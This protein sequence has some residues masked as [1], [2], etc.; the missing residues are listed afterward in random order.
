MLLFGTLE[1]AKV[2]GWVLVALFCLAVLTILV[3]AVVLKFTKRRERVL[4]IVYVCH[5]NG[6]VGFV[7]MED[8]E[9]SVRAFW[10]RVF[11]DREGRCIGASISKV[12][13]GLRIPVSPVF[14]FPQGGEAHCTLERTCELQEA[15]F[16][17]PSSPDGRTP[18]QIMFECW[19]HFFGTEW[20]FQYFNVH[21]WPS[22]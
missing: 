5:V 2:F 15:V 10:K 14:I 13:A 22:Q 8:F 17:L 16:E 19:R 9:R 6:R 3:V 1:N 11:A 20:N 4:P 12:T 21:E 7:L 18:E